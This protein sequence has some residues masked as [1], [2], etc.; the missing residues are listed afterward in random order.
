M[1]Y[2]YRILLLLLSATVAPQEYFCRQYG[3]SSALLSELSCFVP[4]F[5][6]PKTFP[7]VRRAPILADV[8]IG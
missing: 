2:G 8:G 1:R 3:F 5:A 7:N 4:E 6:F